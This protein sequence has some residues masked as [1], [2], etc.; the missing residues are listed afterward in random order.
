[1]KT[2]G[3]IQGSHSRL[4]NNHLLPDCEC[5]ATTAA[6]LTV[7]QLLVHASTVVMKVLTVV[8]LPTVVP[9]HHGSRLQESLEGNQQ[10]RSVGRQ[11][12]HSTGQWRCQRGPSC[13]IG[14]N[15]TKTCRRCKKAASRHAK[16]ATVGNAH[17]TCFRCA[18]GVVN[19]MSLEVFLK[20]VTV[21]KKQEQQSESL[22]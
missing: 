7:H 20:T 2:R 17:R 8:F 15:A 9:E 14:S 10:T 19:L 16:V 3:Q 12:W 13:S 21:E 1:M 4:F 22:L 6:L 5:C 18:D 11:W